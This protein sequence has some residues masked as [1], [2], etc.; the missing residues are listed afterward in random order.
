MLVVVAGGTSSRGGTTRNAAP[1]ELELHESNISLLRSEHNLLVKE[2]EA[3]KS[4]LSKYKMA[5]HGMDHGH[6]AAGD[7]EMIDWQNID[8]EFL[9][10][11]LEQVMTE[12]DALKT[13]QG[14]SV[15]IYW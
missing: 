4:Q 9:S 2:N 6:G 11:K 10:T 14:R 3:L 5:H 12:L 7:R 13:R 15:V 1:T 8:Y